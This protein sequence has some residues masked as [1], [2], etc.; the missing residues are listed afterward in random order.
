M[1][2]GSLSLPHWIIV[3][4]VI[5]LLCGRSRVSGIMGDIGRGIRSFRRELSDVREI[6]DIR[7]K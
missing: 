7:L 2:M 3:A 4:M 1:L 6:T 5:L